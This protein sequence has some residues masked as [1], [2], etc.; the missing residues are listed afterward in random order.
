MYGLCSGADASYETARLDERVISII[1]IDAYCYKTWKWW[2]VYFLPRVFKPGVWQRFFA[3]T[4]GKD[5]QESEGKIDDEFIELPSYIRVFPPKE[6]VEMG[7]RE[8]SARQVSFYNI[9]T[10]GQEEILNYQGQY[11]ESFRRI[12]FGDRLRVDYLPE[13][14][15]IIREPHYQR[16]VVENICNWVLDISSKI[17]G[18]NDLGIEATTR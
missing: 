1:Q 6:A 16:L 14:D 4:F 9:F 11:R 8:L 10:G 17:S 2:F 3:R 13:A 18:N 5:E 7:L 12:N 15:H